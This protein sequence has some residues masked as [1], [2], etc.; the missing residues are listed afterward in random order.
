M[1]HVAL[2]IAAASLLAVPASAQPKNHIGEMLAS[3]FMANGCVLSEQ[4]AVA[5][6]K[7]RGLGIS[8][9]QAQLLAL[10]RGGYVKKNE[11][12]ALQLIK[13]GQNC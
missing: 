3:I 1:R 7:K 8:D 5:E 13:W 11:N 6:M 9:F 12:G 10:H 4:E 2:T